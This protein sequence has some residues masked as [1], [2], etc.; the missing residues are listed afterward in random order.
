LSFYNFICGTKPYDGYPD[1]KT[2]FGQFNAQSTS[3]FG[4]KDLFYDHLPVYTGGN[5]YFN[6]AQPC[7]TEENFASYTEHEITWELDLENDHCVF[8]TNVYDFMPEIH[9]PLV[10][11]ELLGE[12]FEPEQKFEAPDGSPILFDTDY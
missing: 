11:T 1:P 7:D 10:N 12:A 3:D 4:S 8:K 5:V 9:A 6:G 2:Y